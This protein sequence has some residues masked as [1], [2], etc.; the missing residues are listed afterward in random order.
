M[1]RIRPFPNGKTEC[2]IVKDIVLEVFPCGCCH[3]EELYSINFSNETVV[4]F[5]FLNPVPVFVFGCFM[6]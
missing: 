2:H 4:D 6:D 5:N 1:Y 3:R